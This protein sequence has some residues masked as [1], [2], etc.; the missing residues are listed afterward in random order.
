MTSHRNPPRQSR[1]VYFNG[2]FVQNRHH[3]ATLAR[4]F[5]TPTKLL[6]G[7]VWAFWYGYSW[8][9]T[10]SA[11]TLFY[12]TMSGAAFIYIAALV[13]YGLLWT[14]AA[15]TVTWPATSQ[16]AA[17]FTSALAAAA[18]G[19]IVWVRY[20]YKEFPFARIAQAAA[21]AG[22]AAMSTWFTIWLIGW[23][24]AVALFLTVPIAWAVDVIAGTVNR[25][26]RLKRYY[27]EFRREWK[28]HWTDLAA[29]SGRIQS[30]D[31]A[32]ERTVSQIAEGRPI[33]EHP[34]LGTVFQTIYLEDEFAV[35]VPIARPEGR[36]FDALAEVLDEWA[37]QFFTIAN[38][39]RSVRLIYPDDAN[40]N[41]ASW[42]Y[43]RIEF[44][45]HGAFEWP[46]SKD[47][48][49]HP[50]DEDETVFG[51]LTLVSDDDPAYPELEEAS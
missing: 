34:A 31:Q 48:A 35:M 2:F 3:L 6:Q 29:R 4:W 26:W 30:F 22:F 40:S 19:G 38:R 5:K 16:P 11:L 21:A 24:P 20:K 33:L 36:S 49:P 50:V 15:T 32:I 25:K 13:P 17:L 39:D 8:P 41:F 18:G 47:R 7:F 45:D 28:Q 46:W 37:A 43:V 9:I 42:A 23:A 51:G 27:A 10:A 1:G 44:N 12:G 14:I